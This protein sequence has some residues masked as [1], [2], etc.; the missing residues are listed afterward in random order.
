MKFKVKTTLFYRY[1]NTGPRND[2]VG[3]SIQY[4]QEATPTKCGKECQDN[5]ACWSFLIFRSSYTLPYCHLLSGALDLRNSMIRDD[6]D[7]Y[8]IKVRK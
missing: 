3:Q 2:S 5:K 6:V 1:S 7:Y 8:V 4:I